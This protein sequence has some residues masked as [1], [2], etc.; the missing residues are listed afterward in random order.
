MHEQAADRKS[1]EEDS[2]VRTQGGSGDTD[3]ESLA[4]DLDHRNSVKASNLR[5]MAGPSDNRMEGSESE[6]GGVGWGIQ[7][8]EKQW[9]AITK[10]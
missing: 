3:D 8:I 10:R 2:R 1:G 9:K 7:F 4:A 5:R 6:G